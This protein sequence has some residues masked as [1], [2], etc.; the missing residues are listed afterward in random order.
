M[1]GFPETFLS[2]YSLPRHLLVIHVRGDQGYAARL[3]HE[4]KI[5]ESEDLKAWFISDDS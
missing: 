2:P 1:F 4:R 3:N 5:R